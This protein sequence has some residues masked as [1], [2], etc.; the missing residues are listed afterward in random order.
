M[1]ALV[2]TSG[3]RVKGND[4]KR[5]VFLTDLRSTGQNSMMLAG[6]QTTNSGVVSVWEH[7]SF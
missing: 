3:E 4:W 5:T 7:E 1:D 6:A 2:Q